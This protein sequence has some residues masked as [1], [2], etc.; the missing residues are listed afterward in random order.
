MTRGDNGEERPSQPKRQWQRWGH[1]V[2]TF[3]VAVV[4]I[5][6]LVIFRKPVGELKLDPWVAVVFLTLVFHQPIVNRIKNLR[7]LKTPAGDLEF[8]TRELAE[9][10]S[11]AAAEEQRAVEEQQHRTGAPSPLPISPQPSPEPQQPGREPPPG[12]ADRDR[13]PTREQ[14]EAPGL[15]IVEGSEDARYLAALHAAQ[16]ETRLREEFSYYYRL[17]TTQPA[18]RSGHTLTGLPNGRLK[19]PGCST[20]IPGAAQTWCGSVNSSIAGWGRTSW[21]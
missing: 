18:T 21:R 2:M 10:A 9:E 12:A 11:Q 7:S 3:V 6:L 20:V 13:I 17:A 8:Q 1:Q 16:R 5:V 14:E 19:K 4:L 15:I